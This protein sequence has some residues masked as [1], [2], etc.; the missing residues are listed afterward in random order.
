ML[1]YFNKVR[2]CSA[3]TLIIK[4]KTIS[5]SQSWS[6]QFELKLKLTK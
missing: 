6:L 4:M 1:G 3:R 2:D 5:I